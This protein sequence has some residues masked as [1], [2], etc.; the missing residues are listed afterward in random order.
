MGRSKVSQCHYRKLCHKWEEAKSASAITDNRVTNGKKQSQLVALQTIVLQMGRS[1]VSQ[2]HYRQSCH[3]WEEEKPASA[4]LDNRVTN[5][6][7]SRSWTMLQ[8]HWQ[9]NPQKLFG[10]FAKD[11][12]SEYHSWIKVFLEYRTLVGSRGMPWRKLNLELE[13]F[14]YTNIFI[15]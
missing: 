13:P 8:T 5:G 15:S 10:L 12:H 3:K 1:Q 4:I 14:Y 7:K 2:C 9:E 11:P 6:K